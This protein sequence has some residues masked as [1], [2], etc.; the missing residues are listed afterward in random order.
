MTRAKKDKGTKKAKSENVLTTPE[1]TPEKSNT[2]QIQELVLSSCNNEKFTGRF[3]SQD[4]FNYMSENNLL[5]NTPVLVRGSNYN[6]LPTQLPYNREEGSR[7]F[8]QARG[9]SFFSLCIDKIEKTILSYYRPELMI[10]KTLAMSKGYFP[11]KHAEIKA[12]C[13]A[14]RVSLKAPVSNQ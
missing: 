12:R 2:E 10:R 3:F 5:V 14:I 4:M 9:D 6:S 1:T 13:K 7:G 11:E 8:A